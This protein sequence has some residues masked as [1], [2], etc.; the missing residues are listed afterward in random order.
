VTGPGV[1]TPEQALDD[2]VSWTASAGP[3]IL[4]LLADCP[5]CRNSLLYVLDTVP[6][7]GDSSII[8]LRLRALPEHHKRHDDPGSSDRNPVRLR[9]AVS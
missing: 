1:I 4:R 5:L 6:A 2:L 8:G 9:W 7:T 3:G